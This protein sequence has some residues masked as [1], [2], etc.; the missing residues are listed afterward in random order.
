MKK[1]TKIFC[2]LIEANLKGTYLSVT[3]EEYN[4]CTKPKEYKK[5]FFGLAFFHAIILER[6][7]YG[8]IGWNIPYGWM[9]SDIRV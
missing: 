1:K 8:A 4:L 2:V 5:L 3:E 9:D 7:K 6:R